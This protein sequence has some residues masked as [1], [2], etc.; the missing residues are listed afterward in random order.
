LYNNRRKEKQLD[1]GLIYPT[2]SILLTILHKLS[3]IEW[4]K[5]LVCKN[6]VAFYKNTYSLETIQR[7]QRRASNITIDLFIIIKYLFV[8]TLWKLDYSNNLTNIITF[9]LLFYNLFTYFYHHLWSEVAIKDMYLTVHRVRRRFIALFT[10]TFFMII[11]YGYLYRVVID[12]KFK[13]ANEVVSSKKALLYSISNSFAGSYQGLT[14]LNEMAELVK[15][16]Q[17]IMMFTFIS[18]IL[19]R[20]LPQAK[21]KE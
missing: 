10:S 17:T 8:I 7:K 15:V 14:P 5:D 18:L 11:T 6:I 13:W 2:I 4:I 20:S 16:S 21:I 19:A 1:N 3:I 9:Y 12:T